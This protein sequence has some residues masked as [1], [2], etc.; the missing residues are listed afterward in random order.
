MSDQDI[1]VGKP[2]ESVPPQPQPT[3]HL[4]IKVTDNN[5]EVFFKYKADDAAEEAYGRVLRAA[6][7]IATDSQV[8][9]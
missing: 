6:G 5:N 8:L 1:P 4:N 3:E 2:E 7:Q 9:I